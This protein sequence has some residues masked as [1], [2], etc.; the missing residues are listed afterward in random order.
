MRSSRT[1]EDH[2]LYYHWRKT[3]LYECPIC[4]HQEVIRDDFRAHLKIAHGNNTREIRRF[5]RGEVPS[6]RQLNECHTCTYRNCSLSLIK[7]HEEVC[8]GATPS[9]VQVVLRPRSL[10]KV[11]KV[12]IIPKII[13]SE[14]LRPEIETAG[15]DACASPQLQ[16]VD[17]AYNL[18]PPFKPALA[19]LLY[20]VNVRPP[21][22][23]ARILF[24]QAPRPGTFTI[25]PTKSSMGYPNYEGRGVFA[26]D[27]MHPDFLISIFS[28][29]PLD[30][31]LSVYQMQL[32]STQTKPR[33]LLGVFGLAAA[34]PAGI[35]RLSTDGP[36]SAG[37]MLFVTTEDVFAPV[38]YPI[39]D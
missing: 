25:S 29:S 31:T 17:K 34:P 12:K 18:I 21:T 5:R 23:V 6:F 24:D 39:E 4:F 10:S 32:I 33:I 22:I 9:R 38:D 7:Q 13:R 28:H 20:S 27:A 36:L 1:R 37:A 14:S 2:D 35:Y 30:T 11:R 3:E 16:V 15:G 19:G 26:L 8:S